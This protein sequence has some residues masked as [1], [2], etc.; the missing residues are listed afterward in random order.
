MKNNKCLMLMMVL[1]LSPAKAHADGQ[2]VPINYDNLSYFEEPLA[3]E[4][5]PATLSTN[6]LLDQA[7]AYNYK[8]DKDTYN[9]R[10][11]ADF[12]LETELPNSWQLG[13]QYFARYDRLADN[14]ENDEYTDNMAVFLSDELGTVAVGNVTGSVR[15]KTR[16]KRGFG[17]ADLANDDFL[18][19]L[20]ET[21]AY[22]SVR[23]NSYVA[24]VTADQEGRAELGLSFER[25]IGK[26]NY[27]ISSRLRKGHTEDN[28]NVADVG[29]TY[30][31][32]L[33]GQYTYASF[34]ID[35]QLGYEIVDGESFV[36]ENEHIFGSIG[37]QG[38][39]GA[40]RFSAEGSLGEYNGVDMRALSLGS[41]I[42]IAR[43]TSLNFGVNYEFEDDND[44]TT[45]IASI[46][47]EL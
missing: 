33:V 5:G 38:K 46:R 24:S 9:S 23:F 13:A 10:A 37:T 16:R 28:P 7:I 34:L 43:G 31:G 45:S 40:Y 18:G 25:P 15:E 17:H 44:T 11:N 35:A 21:G 36:G 12:V 39:Y 26:G 29:E 3:F 22:Y 6:I 14:D 1:A 41:I 42:D 30:G 47:Y 8:D 27:F 19:A 2:G 20:D 4:I 32:A